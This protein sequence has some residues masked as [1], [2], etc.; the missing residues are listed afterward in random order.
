MQILVYVHHYNLNS[1]NQFTSALSP[2]FRRV[3]IKTRKNCVYEACIMY[4]IYKFDFCLC[5]L[6]IT[7]YRLCHGL[8]RP[9]SGLR[10]PLYNLNSNNQ[11]SSALSPIFRR[12]SIKTMKNC[13]YEAIVL[14][15][16]SISSTFVYAP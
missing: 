12:V 1:K 3:S 14:C 8:A 2:I 15:I 9:D 6:D 4:F 7:Q 10:S 5:P 11:F 16:S 13:L